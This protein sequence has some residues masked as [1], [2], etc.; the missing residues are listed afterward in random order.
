[1]TREVTAG[2]E[3]VDAALLFDLYGDLLTPHQ[4][5]IWQLYYL[6]DWSL[7]EISQAKGISRS[8]VYD[9]LDRTE[10]GLADYE[11]KLG[12]LAALNRRQAHLKALAGA[13][14]ESSERGPWFERAT[15]VL[16]QLAEEEG[17]ADV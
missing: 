16:R 4:R 2:V 5:D 12:L 13:L 17:M 8:A 14:A 9:L 11:G 3:R 15:R 1:M 6:E 10:R 7:A